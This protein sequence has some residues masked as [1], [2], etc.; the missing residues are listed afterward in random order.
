MK[1]LILLFMLISFCDVN[2]QWLNQNS[3]VL[4]T[5]Q[6]VH[7]IDKN[8]GIVCGAGGRILITTNSGVNWSSYTYTSSVLNSVFMINST[9]GY[10]AGTSGKIVRYSNGIIG[11]ITSGTTDDLNAVFFPSNNTGYIVGDFN[12]I[13]KSTNGGLAWSEVSFD[14]SGEKFNEGVELVGTDNPAGSD[15]YYG[16]YFINNNT[17]WVC[18]LDRRIR[19]TTN[20]GTSWTTQSAGS[21]NQIFYDI[22]F[23]DANTGIVVGAE[24]LI[25]RTTNGGT[26]WTQQNSFVTTDLYCISSFQSGLI[27][28]TF[29]VGGAAG[30]I[31]KTNNGGSVW[32]SQTTSSSVFSINGIYCISDDSVF[33][34]AGA[35]RIYNTING[36]G[37]MTNI[38]NNTAELNDFKLYQNYPNP[39]NPETKISFYLIRKERVSLKVYDSRGS[40][41]S[42]PVNG[43]LQAGLYEYKFLSK[44]LSSGI[45]YYKLEAG[46]FTETKKMILVK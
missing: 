28:Y 36:G 7:F 11:E 22:E 39:F 40:L 32:G 24:G 9:T 15:D 35:G 43:F 27:A 8:T 30:K 25:Y 3:G 20:G 44:D 31:L 12:T 38:T 19:K 10:M 4:N 46:S 34:V 18:G 16:L 23:K 14:N 45:Y 21:G 29:Y 1:K 26:N 5:L 13:L 33:A 17:G 37:V 42:E 6:G 41:I 2:S